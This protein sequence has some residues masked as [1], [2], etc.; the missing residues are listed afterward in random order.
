MHAPD[1]AAMPIPRLRRARAE[2][3][4]AAVPLLVE[5]LDVLALELAG[6]GMLADAWPTFRALF[7]QGGNRY[8]FEHV[9][10]LDDGGTL[11]GVILAY[12]G[13]DEPALAAATL[14]WLAGRDPGRVLR[15]QPESR[16][17][18]FYLDALAVAASHRGRGL[19]VRMIEAVCAAA[20]ARGHARAGLLVDEA[21]PGVQRL[22]QQAG[23][24]VDGHC[25]LAGHR[26][27]H[28]ARGLSAR[29]GPAA[30]A[31]SNTVA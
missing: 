24:T 26:Y 14:A 10:V 17:D 19:A 21:K 30:T 1:A 22:Y 20:A 4:P 7:A 15:H 5:A 29:S 8:G 31:P 9:H 11:A 6:V 28:M 2:D 16:P 13:R 12:P 23:F 3:A 18:E 25:D 27:L